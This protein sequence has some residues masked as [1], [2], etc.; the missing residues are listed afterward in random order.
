MSVRTGISVKREC[1]SR[2]DSDNEKLCLW[3]E[4][5]QRVRGHEL[6]STSPKPEVTLRLIF[7]LRLRQSSV[8]RAFPSM[9]PG[10]LIW[11]K[12]SQEVGAHNIH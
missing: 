7:W 10:L 12:L 5:V 8:G 2:E 9:K 6:N 1:G 3:N 11:E 4:E